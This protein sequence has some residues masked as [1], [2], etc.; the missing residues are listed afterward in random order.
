MLRP[1]RSRLES[2]PSHLPQPL[3]GS[4]GR[5]RC[6]AANGTASLELPL[7]ARAASL[8]R[9]RLEASDLLVEPS[10]SLRRATGRQYL[11]LSSYGSPYHAQSPERPGQI[12]QAGVIELRATG[13][14]SSPDPA[15][16]AVPLASRATARAGVTAPAVRV[17]EEARSTASAARAIT[18]RPGRF[19]YRTSA[20][21]TCTL[22][23]R[24]L[25][26]STSATRTPQAASFPSSQH[27]HRVRPPATPPATCNPRAAPTS[28][29]R[30]PIVAGM[31][32]CL[33]SARP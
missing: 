17:L 13:V 21:A 31:T 4:P 30:S 6:G 32:R 7:Q 20:S 15:P 33:L 24:C 12:A 14:A 18:L 23:I 26:S 11:W 28:A 9:P 22:P 1:H 2:C 3:A 29:P 27:P 25:K 5:R 19:S 8:A 10:A 16:R